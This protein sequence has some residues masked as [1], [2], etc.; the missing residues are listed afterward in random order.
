MISIHTIKNNKPISL[1]KIE[2]VS[3]LKDVYEKHPQFR[4]YP[5]FLSEEDAQSWIDEERKRYR[6]TKSTNWGGARKGAG[7]K[8]K[9][10]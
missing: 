1:I 4:G 9:K 7:R 2:C 10:D 8:P 3:E 6:E 5:L